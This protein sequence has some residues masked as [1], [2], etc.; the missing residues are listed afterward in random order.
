MFALFEQL[1]NWLWG[2]P[3]LVTILVTGVFLTV[4]SGFFQFCHMGHIITSMFSKERREGGGDDGKSLTPF[5]AISVAIGGTVGVSNM[6]GVATAIA[7]GGPGALFWLWIAA[8][9]GMVIKMA[10][11]TLAVY[12]REKQPNGEYLGGPTYYMQK[13]L[14]EE[15][16]LPFWKI[17]SVCFGGCIF[18]TWFITLQNFT[19]SEAVGSTFNLPYI[20]PSVLYVLAIYL[21]I[22]G[23]VKKVG[24]IASYL[25]PIMC[26][27]YVVGCVIILIVN[28]GALPET[29]AMIFKGAFTAQA[30][31]GGFV[32]AGVATAMRLGFARSVYSNEA[33]W[34]T[35]PM[36]HASAKTDHPV[37]QGVMGAFEVFADTMVVCTMT[38]LVVITTGYW[39]SGLQGAELTLT[40]FESVMGPVARALIAVS[41]FLFGLTTSTGWFTY[42]SVI[43][44]HWLKNN[45]KV[46]S[47]AEKVF[48]LG[49]PL[50]GML[51]T[52]LTVFGNGTPAQLW[53]IADFTTVFP[54]FV[55][56]ATLF[57]LSGTFVKLLKDYCARY[58][59]KGEVDQ[60]FELFYEDK[61]A[62]EGK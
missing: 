27:L 50:W 41:I 15:K 26:L 31:V 38:G 47:I 2:M 36:I 21:I 8:L 22:I 1:T 23:G 24:V 11:V 18:M 49:T 9:L 45:Q 14:G 12:Y 58:L 13:G 57:I 62:K 34:G 6:S 20:V 42:Y 56:V 54:T 19:V 4:R 3:L 59:G 33:G 17:F 10:E 32:G 61:K 37:K 39:S 28:A 46:L 40:A 35:S 25:T 53:V 44:K 52:V 16:K 55:N 7:T 5:Q 43:L 60:D 48:I 51:V 29:F 30:A